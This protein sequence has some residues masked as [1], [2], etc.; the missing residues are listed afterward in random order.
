MSNND[1]VVVSGGNSGT[2]FLPVCR[3]KILLFRDENVCRWIKSEKFARPLF[4][5]VIRNGKKRFRTQS[6]PLRFH[7][8]R[9]H[10]ECLPCAHLVRKQGVS[11]IKNMRDR[12]FLVFSE[13]NFRIHSTESDVFAVVFARSGTVEKLIVPLDKRM[14]PV[15]SLPNPILESILYSLLFLLSK[16][17]FFG[18]QNPP[19]LAVS[20]GHSVVDSDVTQ[21]QRI[22]DDLI[23]VSPLRTVSIMRAYV[24]CIHAFTRDIPL[25]RD[26]GVFKPNFSSQ[27]KRRVKKFQHELSDITFVNPSRTESYLNLACVEVFWLSL[28]ESGNI[29]FVVGNPFLWES[30]SSIAS[31]NS[32]L[33]SNIAG[34]I[35]VRGL[36]FLLNWVMKD[37]A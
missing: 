9:Y 11:A 15:R 14:T 17:R 33:F 19:L 5:Q 23:S 16:R 12:I 21:I 36:P 7:R 2:E 31:G 37:D 32:E 35:L 8:R 26:L 29:R 3:L 20:V 1:R 24:A 18:V 6:E 13:R 25:R 4:S 30:R 28:F 34:K 22:L 10:L 27:I